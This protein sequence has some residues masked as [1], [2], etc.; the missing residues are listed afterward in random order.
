M[1]GGS[2]NKNRQ[3]EEGVLILWPTW[4]GWGAM[5]MLFVRRQ[6]QCRLQQSTWQLSA[7]LSERILT[8]SPPTVLLDT[9]WP[10]G[11]MANRLSKRF[12]IRLKVSI[13]PRKLSI[14]YR[15]FSNQSGAQVWLM[16]FS[17]RNN[18]APSIISYLYSF[19]LAILFDQRKA[20]SLTSSNGTIFMRVF[21]CAGRMRVPA[22]RLHILP[23]CQ[24]VSVL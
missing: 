11:G 1:W 5:R 20:P 16:G 18:S 19:P 2:P 8:G 14:F 21:H 17:K 12:K 22:F 24:L 10:W 6:W 7:K 3:C 15:S 23:R 4:W 13:N 9:K